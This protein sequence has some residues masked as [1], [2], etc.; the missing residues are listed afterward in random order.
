MQKELISVIV[1]VYNVEQYL[2]FCIDSILN[3]TYK[4]IEVILIDDGSTDHSGMICDEYAKK[5]NRIKVFHVKNGGPSVAR[6]LG[7]F[8]SMGEFISFVDSDDRMHPQMLLRMREMLLIHPECQL[9]LCQFKFDSTYVP[10]EEIIHGKEHV[11]QSEYL[12]DA[13]FTS[14]GIINGVPQRTTI[15]SLLNK[16]YRKDAIKNF[17]FSGRKWFEDYEFNILI[18][19]NIKKAVMSE[20]A[21]FYHLVRE[22]SLGRKPISSQG[23]EGLDALKWCYSNL[24]H[25]LKE[26]RYCCLNTYIYKVLYTYSELPKHRNING[27][28]FSVYEKTIPFL[29]DYLGLGYT[30][31]AKTI[32]TIFYIFFPDYF[33]MRIK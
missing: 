6:N 14:K 24:P 27:L 10:F 19:R 30:H 12:L 28:K 15:T 31:I 2:P 32:K 17:R 3:Q 18:Y 20:S 16:L 8:Y 25:A 26:A 5:D 23:T 4:S 1:P 21:F 7:L 13:M 33:V 29:S 9:A 22:G 11:V